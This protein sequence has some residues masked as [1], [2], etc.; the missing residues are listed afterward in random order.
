MKEYLTIYYSETWKGITVSRKIIEAEDAED[1]VREFKK[2]SEQH[3]NTKIALMQ[4][5][6]LKEINLSEIKSSAELDEKSPK[7]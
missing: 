5:Y 2:F 4:L 1:A 6:E 7:L 3:S